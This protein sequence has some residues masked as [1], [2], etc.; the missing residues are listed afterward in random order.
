MGFCYRVEIARNTAQLTK[1]T[2]CIILLV[3][4]MSCFL[5][6]VF[7]ITGEFITKILHLLS[8]C[9]IF[10][11]N[12]GFVEWC[13]FAKTLRGNTYL[14]CAIFPVLHLLYAKCLLDIMLT[15]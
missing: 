15:A 3:L 14:F 8:T 4:T 6:D 9:A 10:R 12:I 13:G 2:K 11:G 1:M 5:Q 7:G